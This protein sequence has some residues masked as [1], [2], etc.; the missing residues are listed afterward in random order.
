MDYDFD[1]ALIDCD[2]FARMLFLLDNVE[3]DAKIQ[4]NVVL[5]ISVARRVPRNGGDGSRPSLASNRLG[6]VDLVA[7]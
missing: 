2:S 3:T 1:K 6:G 4:T 5:V 7:K